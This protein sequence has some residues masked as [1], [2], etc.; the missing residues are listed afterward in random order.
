MTIR[1]IVAAAIFLGF[2][3]SCEAQK[4]VAELKLTSKSTLLLLDSLRASQ[5]IVTDATDGFFEKVTAVE[6]SI[7]LKKSINSDMNRIDLLPD[8]VR[9]LKTDV[10]SFTADESR[11]VADI[12]KEVGKTVAKFN[13]NILPTEIKLIKTKG[14]HYGDGVYYTRENCIIIPQNEL[15]ARNR[16]EFLATMYHE[17]FHV[18]SRLDHSRRNELYQLIGF[19]SA[20]KSLQVP[21]NLKNRIFFNPDGVDY[22]QIIRLKS[23]QDQDVMAVPI[24]MSNVAGGF[25]SK[26]TSFFSYLDFALFQVKERPDGSWNVITNADGSSTIDFKQFQGEFFRQIGDNTQYI[27]HPDEILADNF[28]F[29]MAIENDAKVK[30]KFSVS[31]QQLLENIKIILVK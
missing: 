22:A 3:I 29:L 24:I 1:S 25:T 4:P 20:G 16:T 31:G 30:N 26:K 5:A 23:A 10:N 17:L 21:E 6:M 9:F 14:N 27:I 12:W 11:W 28:S 13:K 15:D 2:L 18:I 8:Y 19:Q 7:Q